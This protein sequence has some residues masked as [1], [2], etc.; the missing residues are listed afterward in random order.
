MPS[1]IDAKF[2]L[3]SIDHIVAHAT[4]MKC[5]D[6]SQTVHGVPLGDKSLR[7][8]IYCALEEKALVPFSMQDEIRTV[9][10]AMG[11]WVA[12]LKEL[13]IMSPEKVSSQYN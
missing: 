4:V 12:W 7:V 3:G 6:P 9:K 8:F 2:A 1:E 10:Q 13:I 5:D 11:S